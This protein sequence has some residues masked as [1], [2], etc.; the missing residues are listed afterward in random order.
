VRRGRGLHLRMVMRMVL[1]RW[2][3]TSSNRS[4]TY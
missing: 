3:T 2:E 4:T 1:S